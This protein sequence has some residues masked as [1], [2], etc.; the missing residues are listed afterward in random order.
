MR[1]LKL[2]IAM[3]RWQPPSN[4]VPQQHIHGLP[5][6]MEGVDTLIPATLFP[7]NCVAIEN[8]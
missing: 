2:L 5:E 8:N 1:L 7:I 6:G 4:G 3:N